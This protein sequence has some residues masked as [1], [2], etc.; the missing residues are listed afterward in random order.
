MESKILAIGS[1][2]GGVG[3]TTTA[4]TLAHALAL[5]DYHVL[6]IDMDSQGNCAIALGVTPAKTT[7]EA[8][9]MKEPVERC[10][11]PARPNLDLLASDHRMAKVKNFM[12]AEGHNSHMILCDTMRNQND[13]D[14]VIIDNAPS[15]DIANLNALMY[16][17]QVIIPIAVDFLAMIGAKQYMETVAEAK[18]AGASV[19]ISGI[20]PTFYDARV[21]RSEEIL[22]IL[23]ANFGSIVAE[24]IPINTR[25]AEAP[26]ARKTIWEYDP[27]SPGAK[28]YIKLV[29]RVLHDAT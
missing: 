26:N 14:W 17:R 11:A 22:E 27:R 23:K 25:L 21:R 10:I 3:K 2:K 13:Y 28:A 1:E 4:I 19:V 9:V 8:M 5:Q 15:L 12:V 16:A 6:L 18:R 20:L 24:P 7:Y 29:E